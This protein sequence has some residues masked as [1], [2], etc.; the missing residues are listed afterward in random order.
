MVRGRGKWRWL[1]TVVLCLFFAWRINQDFGQ[2]ELNILNALLSRLDFKYLF[3]AE[4]GGAVD[5]GQMQ[6]FR[7]YFI[8]MAQDIPVEAD[9]YAM[10]GFCDAYLGHIDAAVAAYQ[11]SVAINPHMAWAHY[12]L[13]VL[14]LKRADFAKAFEAFN[15]V[16]AIR[17]QAYTMVLGRSKIYADIIRSAPDTSIETRAKELYAS[18]YYAAGVIHQL[19]QSSN[20]SFDLEKLGVRVRVF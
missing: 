20:Q 8:R 3:K 13:G 14:Y 11:K 6:E 19:M 1:L 2:A 5:A 15:N 9:A 12:N 4:Q 18:S 7:R 17:P 10:Q 16:L